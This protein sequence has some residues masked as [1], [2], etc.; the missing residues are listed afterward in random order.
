MTSHVCKILART[1][2]AAILYEKY[3]GLQHTLVR[4]GGFFICCQEYWPLETGR[5]SPYSKHKC[6][7]ILRQAHQT[8]W[9]L[10]T[11]VT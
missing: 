3:V 10:R 7:V 11:A 1:T 4:T 9:C 6:V 8:A 5:K 2:C